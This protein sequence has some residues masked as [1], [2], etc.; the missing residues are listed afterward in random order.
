MLL[1][2]TLIEFRGEY[3]G[4]V[5][6]GRRVDEVV[7]KGEREREINERLMDGDGEKLRA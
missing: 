4:G 3:R 7:K 2:C 6:D 5:G 1:L